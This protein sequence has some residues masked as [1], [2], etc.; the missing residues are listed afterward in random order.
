MWGGKKTLFTT[1]N[2][3]SNNT[4]RDIHEDRRGDIWI[5]TDSGLNRIRPSVE[6]GRSAHQP[7]GVS[8][9]GASDRRD[10]AARDAP[11]PAGGTPARHL[12]WQVESF[13]GRG[14]LGTDYAMGI[15]ET[16][17][18]RVWV[19]TGGGLAELDGDT[20]R[21]HSA[22]RELPSNRLFALEAD[23]DGT[24][25]ITTDGDGLVRYRDGKSRAITTR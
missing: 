17:D 22:P 9:G 2:G 4:I 1:A 11:R 7:P 12:G 18:G 20:F 3:L 8:P 5:A 13:A 10:T 24:V 21:L 23:A 16:P 15:A 6:R 25:W 19:A 14:G